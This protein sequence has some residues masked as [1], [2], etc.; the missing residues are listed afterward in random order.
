MNNILHYEKLKENLPQLNLT[1][2][3]FASIVLNDKD[4]LEE[5]LFLL[6]GEHYNITTIRPQYTIRQ[7]LT[8][9]VVL[10]LY[11]ETI[12]GLVIHLEVQNSDT[13]DHARRNRYYRACI[14]TTLLEKGDNYINLPDLLQI[15][16]TKNDFLKKGQA[17]VYNIKEIT[18]G[19]AELYFNLTATGNSPEKI[20]KLQQYFLN[21]TRDNESSYF[22][23]LVKRVNFLKYEKKGRGIMC[24]IID[25]IINDIKEEIREEA[26]AEGRA[27]G[28]AEGLA[29][30]RIEG[31]T[32]YLYTVL[33]NLGPVPQTLYD[34]INLQ[35]DEECLNL[36]FQIALK[37]KTLEDFSHF[38]NI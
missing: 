11:A 16:I 10:D 20:H 14:D 38:A 35:K 22:P 7:L 32:K 13:D 17:L 24:D 28:L 12:S 21:T 19:A 3:F 18:D 15:F 25:G 4:C 29:E 37:S 8:H 6:T 33:Q 9:S 36:W 1:S 2:D 34:K 23:N 5:L 30:G 26:R 31:Q 27:E